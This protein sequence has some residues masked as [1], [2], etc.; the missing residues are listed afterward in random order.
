MARCSRRVATVSRSRPTA[1]RFGSL[2]ISPEIRRISS[3]WR[4]HRRHRIPGVVYV[5]AAADP[6]IPD[7]RYAAPAVMPTAYLW[8]RSI[9]GGAFFA[10]ALPD[11]LITDQADYDWCLAVAPDNANQIYIGAVELHRGDI[12]G[13]SG[14]WTNIST[15][16]EGDSIHSDQHAICFHPTDVSIVYAGNDGGLF[17]SKDRGAHWELLNDGLAI[18]EIEYLSQD[19]GSPQWLLAG[20][21]D[22]GTIRYTGSAQWEHVAD[23]DGGYCG[24]DQQNTNTV[25]HTFDH[26]GIGRS[27]Q[28]GD[29]NSFA[30]IGPDVDAIYRSAFYAPIAVNASTVAQVGQSAFVSRDSGASWIEVALPGDLIGSAICVPMPDAVYVGTDNGRLFRIGWNGDSWSSA[31]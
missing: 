19:N 6:S 7:P 15:Q 4:W 29:I 1:A 24:V 18:T 21:Q 3:G 30:W 31:I 12:A 10:I 14:P 2:S 26:M 25:F 13:P 20:T 27:A 23:G 17:R 16:L 11:Q 22:N 9:A 8:Q 28:K 5:F